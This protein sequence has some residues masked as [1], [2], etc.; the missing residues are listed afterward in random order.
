[1]G[2]PSNV[3]IWSLCFVGALTLKA[4]AASVCCEGQRLLERQK[5]D[6]CSSLVII[7]ERRYIKKKEQAQQCDYD[8]A[9]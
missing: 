2:N 3:H 6:G 5:N 9:K 7:N 4:E 1:M 8:S